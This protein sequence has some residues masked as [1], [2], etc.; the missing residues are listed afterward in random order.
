MREDSSIGFLHREYL[1]ALIT[2]SNKSELGLATRHAH[3]FPVHITRLTFMGMDIMMTVVVDALFIDG[4]KCAPVSNT[5][6]VYSSALRRNTLGASCF[7][8]SAPP[9]STEYLLVYKIGLIS[10][11]DVVTTAELVVRGVAS[12]ND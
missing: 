3:V 8:G 9:A 7:A 6:L 5:G 11:L 1:S 10:Y 4:M 12:S 2:K